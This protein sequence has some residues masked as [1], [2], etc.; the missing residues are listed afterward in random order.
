VAMSF[1]LSGMLAGA[2]AD[3]SARIAEARRRVPGPLPTGWA[4]SAVTTPTGF[5]IRLDA[6]TRVTPVSFFSIDEGV[7]EEAW[8]RW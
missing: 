1:P 3:W 8:P 4:A 2:T 5:E 7:I 6:P